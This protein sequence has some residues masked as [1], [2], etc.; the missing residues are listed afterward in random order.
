MIFPLYI[1]IQQ[2]KTGTATPHGDHGDAGDG[3]GTYR[4]FGTVGNGCR[5]FYGSQP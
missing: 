3:I 1:V 4:V 2:H 5:Y